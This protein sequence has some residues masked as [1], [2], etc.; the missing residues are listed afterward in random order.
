MNDMRLEAGLCDLN[1][2]HDLYGFIHKGLRKAQA[3]MLVRLG[4]EDMITAS[5]RQTLADLRRLLA[6]AALHIKHEETFIHPHM[7]DAGLLERQHDHH[8]DTF[9]RLENLIRGIEGAPSVLVPAHARRLYLAFGHYVAQD[10]LHMYEEETV[11]QPHLW[12]SMT[13][14]QIGA[15]EGAIMRSI[16]PQNMAAFMDLIVPALSPAERATLPVAEI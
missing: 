13:D 11:A 15:I 9:Q 3:D 8:R 12:A 1:G 5:G 14:A 6:L 7:E 10:L 4:N 16:S 2:R